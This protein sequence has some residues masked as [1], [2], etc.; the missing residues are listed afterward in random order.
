M[1]LLVLTA[2]AGR[3]GP[4]AG[5]VAVGLLVLG[6]LQMLFA[7]LGT[8]GAG[9]RLPARDQRARDLCRRQR[10]SRIARGRSVPPA[11]SRVASAPMGAPAGVAVVGSGAGRLL[12]SRRAARRRPPVE[13]DMIERLPT[14][15]GLVRLGVAPDHPKIKS[16]SRAFEKIAAAAGL[17][18][19]RQRRGRPRRRRT[20]SCSSIYDAV[21]YAVGAQTDRRMGI[22]GEDLPGLV[23]GDRV[24]RLVQRPPRLPGARVRPLGRA[25]GRDRERQRRGRRRAHARADAGGARADRHDRRGDR[26]VQR[27]RHPRRS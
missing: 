13:V 17:P 18:L 15:W 20:T 3:L 25:R 5:E 7:S 1:L 8:V 21:V 4:H 19:P 6:I 27:R 12:R 26:R 22:P 10:C 16:V 9:A 14:P 11:G 24:R 2:L 23:G